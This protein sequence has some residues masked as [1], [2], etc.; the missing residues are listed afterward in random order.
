MSRTQSWIDRLQANEP[1]DWQRENFL[2][3]LDMLRQGERFAEEAIARE[4]Q[5]N[6]QTSYD[7]PPR[8]GAA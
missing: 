6:E 1:I 2:L 4:V 5:S 8:G 7:Q 3:S